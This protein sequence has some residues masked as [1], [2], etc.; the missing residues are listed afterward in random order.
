MPNKGDTRRAY[1][2]I[3]YPF[4]LD[5]EWDPKDEQMPSGT[6]QV[7]INYIPRG[8]ILESRK[9]ITELSHS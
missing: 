6:F 1:Y 9:G 4:S 8:Q 3:Q 2:P 5:L 7:L